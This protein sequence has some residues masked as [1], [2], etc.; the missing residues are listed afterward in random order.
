MERNTWT[1]VKFKFQNEWIPVE[2]CSSIQIKSN[3][4]LIFGGSDASIEDSKQSYLFDTEAYTIQ[5]TPPL[6]KAHVFVA[7]PFMHGN[8]VFAVGNEYY[9]KGRNIHRYNIESG[10]WEIIF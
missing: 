9:V 5:K 6:K 2:V 7:A 1:I 3:K 4:I 10:E 8:Y